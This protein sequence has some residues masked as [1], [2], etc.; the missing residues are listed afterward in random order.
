[1]VKKQYKLRS[2]LTLTELVIAVAINIVV[3]VGITVL[4]V[5]SQRGW[6]FMYNRLNS[7]VVTSSYVAGKRFDSVVRKACGDKFSLDD[8]GRWIEVYYYK[9][10][11]STTPNLYARFY[12]SDGDL[13]VEYGSLDPRETD[14]VQ[15][16][17]SNVSD[18]VFKKVGKSAQ[19]ILKLDSG[20]QQITAV[21]SA[22]MHN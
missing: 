8:L 12:E 15:T 10:D 13:Y 7:D 19:M 5:D 2:A 4:L 16:V 20:S 6:R 18:C 3:L 9:D 21:T 14:S 22:V 17:C 1:M 11:F